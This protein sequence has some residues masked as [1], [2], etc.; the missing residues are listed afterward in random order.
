[1]ATKLNENLQNTKVIMVF[2]MKYISWGRPIP[3][4]EVRIVFPHIDHTKDN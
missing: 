2:D 1:M 3:A 4:H